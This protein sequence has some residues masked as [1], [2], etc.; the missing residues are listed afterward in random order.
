MEKKNYDELTDEALL[1]E[2]KKL[3]KSKILHATLIGFLAGIL[4][5]GVVA[6][7]LSPK[8]Q[9]GFLIPM[10]IPIVFI[11]RL[12]KNSKTNKDLEDVLKDRNLN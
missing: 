2:K 4:I 10:L 9:F 12:V 7:S 1:L 5:F 8:K 6:W 11:Y 3:K